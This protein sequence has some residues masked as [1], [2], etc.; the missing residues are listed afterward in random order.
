MLY[1]ANLVTHSCR[2]RV[3]RHTHT[4]NTDDQ[5]NTWIKLKSMTV[6]NSGEQSTAYSNNLS[7]EMVNEYVTWCCFIYTLSM[8]NKYATW[9]CFIYPQLTVNEY[10]TWCCFIYPQSMVNECVTWCQSTWQKKGDMLDETLTKHTPSAWTSQAFL[11]THTRNS[12]IQHSR[13]TIKIP[14]N[15]MHPNHTA[16]F[17]VNAPQ[18][19]FCFHNVSTDVDNCQLVNSLAE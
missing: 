7:D 18:Q 15:Y 9:C 19:W 12:V 10:V 17:T 5:I 6:K 4:S 2:H 1:E 3:H 13:T 14:A 8:A 16:S 11:A